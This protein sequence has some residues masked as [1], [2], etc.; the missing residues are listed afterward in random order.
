M[1]QNNNDPDA[2]NRRIARDAEIVDQGGSESSNAWDNNQRRTVN[3]VYMPLN[4]FDGCWPA[5]VTFALFFACLGQYGV[6]GGIGFLVFHIIGSIMG[7]LRAARSLALGRPWNP[8]P[9]RIGNWLISFIITA[10]LA[11]GFSQ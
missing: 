3:W 11:G 7:S 1:S 6:L 2:Q 4:N 10:W 8:L 5:L 9:W